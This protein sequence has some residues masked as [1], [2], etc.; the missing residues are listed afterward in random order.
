MVGHVIRRWIAACTAVALAAAL[1]AA[2]GLSA[3]AAVAEP[4]P[5]RLGSPAASITLSPK[6]APPTTRVTV[7]GTAF[8]H[9]DR[10]TVLFARKQVASAT[11][12]ESGAFTATFHVPAGAPPGQHTVTAEG[13]PSGRSAEATF[14]VRTNWAQ[15]GF[16][17]TRGLDN[18]FENVISGSNIRKL[19]VRWTYRFAHALG[20]GPSPAVAAGIVYVSDGSGDLSALD[21]AT[22]QARWTVTL[23]PRHAART[24]TVSSETAYV[25]SETG[26]HALDRATGAERWQF[27][28]F[29]PDVVTVAN[30]L[31]YVGGFGG[32]YA[33]D[34]ATGVEQWWT[35]VP[36]TS[37]AV[38]GTQLLLGARDGAID[39]L[40]GSTGAVLWRV[41]VDGVP[42]TPSVAGG[43][44][45]AAT[46]AGTVYALRTSD[47]QEVWHTQTGEQGTRSGVAVAGKR[48]FVATPT[49]TYAFDASSGAVL[50]QAAAAGTTPA[51]AADVVYVGGT[52]FDVSTGDQLW[53]SGLVAPTPAVADGIAYLTATKGVYA[54]GR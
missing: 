8:G 16:D 9:G 34:P 54:F 19:H 24:V 38:S 2:P 35:Y 4:W 42:S 46:D 39:A 45:Y 36:G 52:A 25:S 53:D 32:V 37:P 47:G 18:R 3:T 15:W 41:K 14:T 23:D 12:D 48:V 43:T 28:L 27:G 22:G 20:L 13:S 44:V 26:V 30:G 7:H 49:S 11:A 40:N 31:V 51:V 29:E 17:A 6:F 1:A 5:A 33:L 10:V 50:W 21:A